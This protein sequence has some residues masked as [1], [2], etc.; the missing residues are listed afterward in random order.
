MRL[1][2]IGKEKNE[3]GMR[4]GGWGEEIP[5]RIESLLKLNLQNQGIKEK[6]S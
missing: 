3:D 4:C 6:G 1:G 5:R 2:G